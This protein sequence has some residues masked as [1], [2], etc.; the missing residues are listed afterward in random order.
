[1]STEKDKMLRGE[2]YDANYDPQLR[3]ERMM[4]KKLCRAYNDLQPDDIDGRKALLTELLGATGKEFY[5]E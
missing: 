3:E 5:I 1:M 4:S 2:L